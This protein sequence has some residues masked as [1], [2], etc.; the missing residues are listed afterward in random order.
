MMGSTFA[1]YDLGTVE[2]SNGAPPPP[3]A[4][5]LLHEVTIA[6]VMSM[7]IIFVFICWNF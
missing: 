2:Q 3:P 4:P 5:L 6:V 7:K 1:E